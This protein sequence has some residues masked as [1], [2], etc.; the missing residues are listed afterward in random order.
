[1][2]KLKC[3]IIDDD[4]QI[5]ELIMYF[6]EKSKFVDFCISCTDPVEG[7]KL[8]SDNIFDVLFL[9][10]NMP[11]LN[12][13]DILNI[14][15]DTS[16]VIMITS[17]TDF[18]VTSYKYDQIID[19]LLKPIGYDSFSKA[20]ERILSKS[21]LEKTTNQQQSNATSL[22][23]KTGNNWVQLNHKEILYIKSES[24][25]CT[26]FTKEGKILTL[27]N[28]KDLETKL[29]SFFIRCHRS[30]IVNTNHLTSLNLEEI[31]VNKVSIPVSNSY[32]ETIKKFIDS[33]LY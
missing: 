11:I 22:L 4:P 7:I 19:Y 3:L 1:M 23:V 14:K 21:T 28:L 2:K 9:D 24:N 31:M 27:L 18:A 26:F 10:Y 25:Y 29:P 16:K 17:N 30:Y 13:Q 32:K 5:T 20:L 6:S 15:K 33:K 8:L 12:G